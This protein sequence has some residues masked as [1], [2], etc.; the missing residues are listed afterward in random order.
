MENTICIADEVNFEVCRVG[1]LSQRRHRGRALVVR[2]YADE[3]DTEFVA[4]QRRWRDRPRAGVHRLMG[5]DN[6]IFGQAMT[7]Q[8]AMHIGTGTED[9]LR[10][11]KLPPPCQSPGEDFA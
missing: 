2:Q 10:V 6:R 8:A 5:H 11:E 7:H 4:A 1:S 3:C 9:P